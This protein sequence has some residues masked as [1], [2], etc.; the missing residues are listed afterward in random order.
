MSEKTEL[1][2]KNCGRSDFSSRNKLF[3]HL[4]ACLI[5]R[6]PCNHVRLL[7]EDFL[8]QHDAYLYVCGGRIRGKTLGYVER[9]DFSSRT[10][11]KMPS[12]LENRGSHVS[13]SVDNYVYVIGGGGFRSNLDTIERID[14]LT[15]EIIKLA[16]MP[17]SRHALTAVVMGRSIYTIGM[18]ICMGLY[19]L[20]IIMC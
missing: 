4:K 19:R 16:S 6:N 8:A 11:C 17:V 1:V 10:W 20:I 15:N 7:D 9:Y 5:N 2:C 13:V 14:V 12:L 3:S 18:C